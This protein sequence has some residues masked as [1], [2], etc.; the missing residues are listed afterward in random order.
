MK[1]YPSLVTS[2]SLPHD[3]PVYLLEP[4]KLSFFHSGHGLLMPRPDLILLT[5]FMQKTSLNLFVHGEL[6]TIIIVMKTIQFCKFTGGNYCLVI[7]M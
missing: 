6:S 4:F 3:M 5:Y 1:P 2:L 7:R